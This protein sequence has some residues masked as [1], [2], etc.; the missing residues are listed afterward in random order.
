ML[1]IAMS[2]WNDT[3]AFMITEDDATRGK[4]PL[5]NITFPGECN[6]GTSPFCIELRL[7]L[8]IVQ[9]LLRVAYSTWAITLQMLK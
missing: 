4:H 1:E 5:K 3:L 6:G 8:I 7:V 2:V 9:Q